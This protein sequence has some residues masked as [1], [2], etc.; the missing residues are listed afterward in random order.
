MQ[1]QWTRRDRCSVGRGCDACEDK[2]RLTGWTQR[3]RVIAVRRMRK[4]DWVVE[5]KRAGRPKAKDQA[6]AELHSID[7][8]KPVK[9]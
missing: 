8:N 3:R 1:R 6:Q 5:V 9:S 7:E 2:L 4:S